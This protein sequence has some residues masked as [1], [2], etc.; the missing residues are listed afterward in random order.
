MTEAGIV[1]I[2]GAVTVLLRI[3]EALVAYVLRRGRTTA[4]D[5]PPRISAKLD[6]VHGNGITHVLGQRCNPWYRSRMG[7]TVTHVCGS[8]ATTDILDTFA[9]GHS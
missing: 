4:A 8:C 1:A 9:H 2:A 3:G 6:D 7:E 5:Q